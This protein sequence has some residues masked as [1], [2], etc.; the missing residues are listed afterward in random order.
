MP[1]LA[2]LLEE[3]LELDELLPEITRSSPCDDAVCV[4]HRM[5]SGWVSRSLKLYDRPGP[6]VDAIDPLL[7]V[8][9][10]CGPGG[11][12]GY[13]MLK[14]S[15]DSAV[16]DCGPRL[17]DERDEALEDELEDELERDEELN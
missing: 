6:D 1:E 10:R 5:K 9:S 4:N 2:D 16:V 3:L 8:W 17:D 15:L 13:S 7:P 11:T 14:V 12:G